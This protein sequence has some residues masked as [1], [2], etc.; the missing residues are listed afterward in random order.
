MR[1]GFN[2]RKQLIGLTA[3]SANKNER[4]WCS[5]FDFH[6]VN[7]NAIISYTISHSWKFVE[8]FWFILYD[9]WQ[10]AFKHLQSRWM[11][12]KPTKTY[13]HS[14]IIISIFSSSSVMSVSSGKWKFF[15]FYFYFILLQPINHK[16]L[17]IHKIADT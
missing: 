13:Y 2:F 14:S 4:V 1:V 5:D 9:Y 10:S 8:V 17:K 7:D 3:W 12:E 16:T 6:S 11:I 15:A